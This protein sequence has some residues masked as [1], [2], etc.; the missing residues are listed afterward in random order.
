VRP[1]GFCS[2]SIH[3]IN[4]NTIHEILFASWMC[5][6]WLSEKHHLFPFI[7]P[8]TGTSCTT[9]TFHT[10]TSNY[11]DKL[12]FHYIPYLQRCLDVW[13]SQ[14]FRKITQLYSVVNAYTTSMMKP[15][16]ILYCEINQRREVTLFIES[17]YI[18]YIHSTDMLHDFQYVM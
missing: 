5:G 8:K 13:N 12:S 1:L 7:R 4:R 14:V 16:S 15:Y 11:S 6:T 18:C 17:R 10:V 9:F 2:W 3:H